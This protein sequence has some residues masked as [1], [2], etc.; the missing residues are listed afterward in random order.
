MEEMNLV[1]LEKLRT[2]AF[3]FLLTLTVTP[4]LTAVLAAGMVTY[5]AVPPSTRV[6]NRLFVLCLPMLMTCA[7]AWSLGRALP[8]LRDRL[9]VMLVPLS[10]FLALALEALWNSN[11]LAAYG[12]LLLAFAPCWLV[13]IYRTQS[14]LLGLKKS[15]YWFALHHLFSLVLFISIAARADVL[16][17][18]GT[19]PLYWV[20]TLGALTVFV[21]ESDPRVPAENTAR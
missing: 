7:S 11:G 21:N 1:R 8:R 19:V 6:W 9:K 18:V 3:G 17:G 20:A 10:A 13:E 4:F 14:A 2:S 12:L 16:F 15:S 5:D